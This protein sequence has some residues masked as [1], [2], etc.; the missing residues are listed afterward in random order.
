M[1]IVSEVNNTIRV[2]YEKKDCIFNL[3][4]VNRVGERL[5][6]R[7]GKKPI[8]AILSRRNSP[9]FSFKACHT[10]CPV[11]IFPETMLSGKIS[12]G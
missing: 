3:C 2:F 5:L 11:E 10:A 8:P 1:E 6:Q 7:M 12:C 9:Y 4:Q